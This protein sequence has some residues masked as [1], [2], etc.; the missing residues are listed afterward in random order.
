VL[1]GL[2][3]VAANLTE[4]NLCLAQ[5]AAVHLMLPDLPDMLVPASLAAEDRL[6]KAEQTGELL[7][8][9]GWD[10]AEHPRAGV[11]PNRGWF[12]PTGGEPAQVAQGEED[13]R[14]PEEMTDPLAEVRQARWNA[15]IARLR[16]I[17]P[18]NPNLAYFENRDT[19]PSEAA[20][21]RLNAVVEAAAIKRVTD[22]VMPDGKP[23][24]RPGKG[25]DVRELP[26]GL[27]AAKAL[28]D[29]LRVGGQMLDR[30]N[31]AGTLVKLPGRA[32]YLTLRPISTSGSPAV[33]INVPG[34]AF[35][36]IHFPLGV[37]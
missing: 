7:N 36:K 18:T 8:R 26:G 11:P 17:D 29:Y 24:G 15:S 25:A 4:Q 20:I 31:L 30:P 28:F 13:E 1:P 27:E 3:L 14:A 35:D 22:K 19:V 34:V 21:E 2:A 16:E 6:I 12:A 37:R 5:I 32:G 10:P 9:T 23:I 33:D